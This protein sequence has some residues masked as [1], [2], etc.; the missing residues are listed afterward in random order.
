MFISINEIIAQRKFDARMNGP[1][2]TIKFRH[3]VNT[4]CFFHTIFNHVF[5]SLVGSCGIFLCKRFEKMSVVSM[6]MINLLVKQKINSEIFSR[7]GSVKCYTML[8]CP[9]QKIRNKSSVFASTFFLKNVILLDFTM[10]FSSS[11]IF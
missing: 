2:F 9:K 11:K 5:Y 6:H 8:N 4:I 1:S 10:T 3:V 7:M